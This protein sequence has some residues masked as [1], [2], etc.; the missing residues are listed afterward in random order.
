MKTKNILIFSII[1]FSIILSLNLISASHS[2]V[3][4]RETTIDLHISCFNTTNSFCSSSTNCQI[5]VYYPNQ[6][7]LALNQSM[8]Y[9]ETFYNY[10][11]NP[12]QTTE[13]GEHNV[14]I[15]CQGTENAFSTFNFLITQEG[16]ERL[17]SGEGLS[18]FGSI[19]VML[20]IG[21][22]FFFISF[23]FKGIVGKIICIGFAGTILVIALLYSLVILNQVF[24]G[25]SVLTETYSNFWFVI[26]IILT[27][28]L[29]FFSLFCFFYALKL[30][31]IKRGLIDEN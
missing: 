25:F 26:R 29:T 21:I 14:I 6:S 13:L 11:L 12:T 18:L 17:N 1:L 28:V 15:N 24:G 20:F 10:S 23:A 19:I 16:K 2:F 9:N 3:F 27:V 4:E 7:V 30:W 31:K 5:S 22:F 8:T